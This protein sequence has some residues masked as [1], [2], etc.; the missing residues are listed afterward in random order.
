MEGEGPLARQS[1]GFGSPLIH[2]RH[3][4]VQ[5][6][7]SGAGEAASNGHC[8]RVEGGMEGGV[9]GRVEGGVESGWLAACTLTGGARLHS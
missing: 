7:I 4:E 2:Q 1:Y 3:G 6:A 5:L 9:E 8:R